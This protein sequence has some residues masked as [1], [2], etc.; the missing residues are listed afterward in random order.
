MDKQQRPIVK[1]WNSAQYYVP[2]WLGGG[3]REE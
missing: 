1:Q 2:A 3:V